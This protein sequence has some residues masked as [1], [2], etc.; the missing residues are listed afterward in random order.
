M[1]PKKIRNWFR[2]NIFWT[3]ILNWTWSILN[4]MSCNLTNTKE[5]STTKHFF[6]IQLPWQV[7]EAFCYL[8]MHH[9]LH[10]SHLIFQ[11]QVLPDYV[12]GILDKVAWKKAK[13]QKTQWQ[14]NKNISKGLFVVTDYT[15]WYSQNFCSYEQLK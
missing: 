1:N 5:K 3:Q 14:M 9:V 6:L 4:P 12:F 11:E 10:I 13:Y 2:H 8:P 7:S 15:K